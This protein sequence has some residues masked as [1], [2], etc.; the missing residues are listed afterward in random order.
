MRPK[1][2][3]LK[4]I[5]FAHR[6]KVLNGLLHLITVKSQRKGKVEKKTS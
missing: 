4:K 5:F 1:N 6:K 2:L 3:T